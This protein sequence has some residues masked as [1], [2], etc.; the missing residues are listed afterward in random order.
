MDKKKYID[1]L[2]MCIIVIG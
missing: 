1:Q 2:Y